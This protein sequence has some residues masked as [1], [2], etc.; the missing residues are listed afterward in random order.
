MFLVELLG[1]GIPWDKYFALEV[2]VGIDGTLI[3]PCVAAGATVVAGVGELGVTLAQRRRLVREVRRAFRRPVKGVRLYV[4]RTVSGLQVV[5]VVLRMVTGQHCAIAGLRV[6]S[7][8]V[9]VCVLQ[10]LL[11]DHGSH[12]VQLRELGLERHLAGHGLVRRL[13]K[14]S[15]SDIANAIVCCVGQIPGRVLAQVIVLWLRFSCLVPVRI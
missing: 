9:N 13:R 8:P 10:R 12:S 4:V 1:N 11:G 5:F 7:V 6:S 2:S 15:I 3:L 14:A